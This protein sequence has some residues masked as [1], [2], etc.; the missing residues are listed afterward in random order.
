M[1]GRRTC[2]V[3]SRITL[4]DAPT[5]RPLRRA[6]CLNTPTRS[7]SATAARAALLPK[8]IPVQSEVTGREEREVRGEPTH[9]PPYPP[10]QCTCLCIAARKAGGERES[11]SPPSGPSRSLSLPTQAEGL[12]QDKLTYIYIYIYIRE[13]VRVILELDPRADRGEEKKAG[14]RQEQSSGPSDSREEPGPLV[15]ASRR[16]CRPG[17]RVKLSSYVSTS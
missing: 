2:L 13:T 12:S 16:P 17:E 1:P 9:D 14:S 8:Q 10:P 5:A 15:G 4:A 6:V 3:R 11:T 7:A